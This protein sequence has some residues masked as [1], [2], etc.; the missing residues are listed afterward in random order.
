MDRDNASVASQGVP[1]FGA[2]FDRR[3]AAAA[4]ALQISLHPP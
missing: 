3:A 1:G 4:L 2:T